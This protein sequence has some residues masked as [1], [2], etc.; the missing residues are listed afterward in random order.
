MLFAAAEVICGVLPGVASEH[1]ELGARADAV[2][3]TLTLPLEPRGTAGLSL[4]SDAVKVSVPGFGLLDFTVKVTLPLESVA[5][6]EL[7]EPVVSL[8]MTKPES[9]VLVKVTWSPDKALP[10]E[11]FTVIEIV[12]VVAPSAGIV[13]GLT[14]IVEL[15]VSALLFAN[16]GRANRVKKKNNEKINVINS[17]LLPDIN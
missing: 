1:E 15:L 2:K 7:V 10:D 3:F 5:A 9:V 16:T 17:V 8:L 14:E 11:S 6:V 4:V 13:L 12:A